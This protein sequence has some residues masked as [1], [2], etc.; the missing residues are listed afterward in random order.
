MPK[1]I[2]FAKLADKICFFGVSTAVIFFLVFNIDLL[3]LALIVASLFF[4]RNILVSTLYYRYLRKYYNV[5][6]SDAYYEASL[7]GL[8]RIS[9]FYNKT[10][11][12]DLEQSL[13]NR[14]GKREKK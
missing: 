1:W 4:A 13:K 14:F 3:L 2:V 9:F 6:K 5:G 8:Y 12:Q 10:S 11:F 7:N